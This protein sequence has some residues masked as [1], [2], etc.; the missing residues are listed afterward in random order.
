MTEGGAT[1][2]RIRGDDYAVV[3]IGTLFPAGPPTIAELAQTLHLQTDLTFYCL[4]GY[5]AN[6]PAVIGLFREEVGGDVP[7]L[8]EARRRLVIAGTQ[9]TADDIF[10]SGTDTPYLAWPVEPDGDKPVVLPLSKE[11]RQVLDEATRRRQRETRLASIAP[12]LDALRDELGPIRD[13]AH[14][15]VSDIAVVK[16]LTATNARE[17]ALLE[18]L[19][20]LLGAML[21]FPKATVSTGDR[22]DVEQLRTKLGTLKD[23]ANKNMILD[24]PDTFTEGLIK[25]RDDEASELL[26]LVEAASLVDRVRVLVANRDVAPPDLWHD[27]L[28]AVRLAFQALLASPQSD[29][30]LDAHVLPMIDALA[31]KQFDLTGLAAPHLPEFDR[32][33]HD[34]PETPAP[35]SALVVLASGAGIVPQAV[36]NYPGPSTLAVSLLDLAAP[37]LM[38]RVVG[39]VQAGGLLAGHLYRVLVNTATAGTGN[40]PL[41]MAQR[42]ELIEAID[43]GNLAQLRTINWSG[44]FMNSP[45]WGS[46]IAIASG[47]CL[48]A[49]IQSDD[50]STLRRWSNIVGSASGSALGV[51][52]ALSRYSTLVEMG[53]VR[54]PVGRALGVIGGLAAVVSGVVTAEEEYRSG[55]RVGMW[56]S[57]GAATG[58]ALSVAGF[59]VCAGAGTTATVAG[60]PLGIVLMAAGAI[61]GVG[62]GIVSLVRTVITAGSQV[63]F[64]AFV[65]HFGRPGG[66]YDT[67][68]SARPSLRSAFEAV[69]TGHHGVDFWDVDPAKVPQLFDLGFAE[70]H[71]AQIVHE[72]ATVVHTSLLQSKRIDS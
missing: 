57:I 3:T 55:D 5:R 9:F 51:S 63:I 42:L 19:D 58:G 36:G 6:A 29:H 52:V 1:I 68:A 35:T 32:G 24:P 13:K 38:A 46:A 11:F 56:V 27:T 12:E 31:S 67:A 40:Q 14:A 22:Q 7:P 44:R 20:G 47:I 2:K 25:R 39:N 53:I 28:D 17:L 43:A 64:G 48:M 50:S 72:D 15:L 60:A 62:A 33:V 34:V 59:L 16:A 70:P 30:V 23:E 4:I 65:D 18:A 41:S 37:M 71:I 61:I 26:G 45:A 10:P 21:Q 69:Q 8:E 49:A 54:S 66:P